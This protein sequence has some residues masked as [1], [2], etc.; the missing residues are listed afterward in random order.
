VRPKV[1]EAVCCKRRTLHDVLHA[2]QVGKDFQIVFWPSSWLHAGIYGLGTGSVAV[3]RPRCAPR[4][5][6]ARVCRNSAIGGW[7]RWQVFV[8]QLRCGVRG[9]VVV[10]EECGVSKAETGKRV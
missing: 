6:S 7:Q 9:S 5:V 3:G 2:C 4:G 8:W 10:G 1:L